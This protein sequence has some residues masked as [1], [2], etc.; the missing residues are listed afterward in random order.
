MDR[1]R[2]DAKKTDHIQIRVP[3]ETKKEFLAACEEDK[4]SASDVLRKAILDYLAARKQMA[5]DA[6]DNVMKLLPRPLRKRR[7]LAAAAAIVGLAVVTAMPSAAAPDFAGTFQRL[8]LNHDGALTEDEFALRG[9]KAAK[10]ASP[11]VQK[12]GMEV[13]DTSLGPVSRSQVKPGQ[14]PEE[15]VA[16]MFAIAPGAGV[17]MMVRMDRSGVEPDSKVSADEFELAL[18]KSVAGIFRTGDSN[19]DGKLDARELDLQF[20]PKPL[21]AGTRPN[22][23]M[24]EQTRQMQQISRAEFQIYD[25]DGDG[26]ITLDEALEGRLVAMVAAYAPPR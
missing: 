2:T 19:Q 24:E 17:H 15:K 25:A 6:V 12:F 9:E 1:D 13:Y 11:V 7:Y 4:V 20:T 3:P 18:R 5:T 23:R 21:P 22:P 10:Y 14:I 26:M 16:R 8:D